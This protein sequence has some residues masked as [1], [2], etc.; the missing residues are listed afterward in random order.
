LARYLFGSDIGI[1]RIVHEG[2]TPKGS[3]RP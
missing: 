1:L 2:F 3:E